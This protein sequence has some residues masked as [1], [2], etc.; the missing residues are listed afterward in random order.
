M[1]LCIESKVIKKAQKR[2][3]NSPDI[4]YLDVTDSAECCTGLGDPGRPDPLQR[5]LGTACS[6]HGHSLKSL[7]NLCVLE[8]SHPL[9]SKSIKTRSSQRAAQV[10]VLCR[11]QKR[12]DIHHFCCAALLLS[13]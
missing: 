7:S 5:L 4:L 3:T 2:P 12:T 10:R 6:V 9:Y 8:A 1:D 11:G 13:H